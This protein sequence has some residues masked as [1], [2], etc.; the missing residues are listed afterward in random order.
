MITWTVEQPVAL[1]CLF[2]WI[3][4]VTAISF[5]EAWL[6]FRAPGVT[7]AIGLGIGRLVFRALNKVEWVLALMI[8]GS[9][10]WYRNRGA[11]WPDVF[12]FLALFVLIIQTIWLLP[13]MNKR[14]ALL[15]NG[16]RVE[17]SNMHVYFVA[18]ELIKVV[19]LCLAG[20]HLFNP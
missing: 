8:M 15:I 3:G 5:L 2:I 6:K 20:V 18:G 12:F 4:F 9:A 13:I 14:A 19:S 10:L 11:F 16:M 7:L 17:R 1:V